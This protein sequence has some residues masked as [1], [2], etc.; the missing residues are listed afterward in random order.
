MGIK[1]YCDFCGREL[2]EKEY[3]LMF[4]YV[5][6]PELREIGFYSVPEGTPI[7]KVCMKCHERIQEERNYY[8]EEE[9]KRIDELKQNIAEDWISRV[10]YLRNER[11]ELAE[12][13]VKKQINKSKVKQS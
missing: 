12:K 5:D 8:K 9:E 2:N 6:E 1:Y 13:K 4:D 11:Q 3:S 10:E 7:I